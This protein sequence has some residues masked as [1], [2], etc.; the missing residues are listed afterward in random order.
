MLYR[1]CKW[2]GDDLGGLYQQRSP[3]AI[4]LWGTLR[5]GCAF[6]GARCV[7]QAYGKQ[8]HLDFPTSS[9][10]QIS[11]LQNWSSLSN[12]Q[13]TQPLMQSGRH[14]GVQSSRH[15]FQPRNLAAPH[16]LTM[17]ILAPPPP[18]LAPKFA[19][20]RQRRVSEARFIR[21]GGLGNGGSEGG[22]AAEHSLALPWAGDDPW[23][24]PYKTFE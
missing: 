24:M 22:G 11:V 10:P 7:R 12:A 23:R 5:R 21:I 13:A 19:E 18:F 1:R 2:P 15:P 9:C 17:S 16:L 20:G 3:M 14:P 8:T 6:S 4:L